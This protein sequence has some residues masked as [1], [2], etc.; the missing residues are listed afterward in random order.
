[1]APRFVQASA[2]A[3]LITTCTV[4]THADEKPLWEAGLGIGAIAFPDYR[5]QAGP[6]AF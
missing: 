1:M 4:R 3:L 6:V 2:I 5:W